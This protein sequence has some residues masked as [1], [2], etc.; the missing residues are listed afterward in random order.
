M[1]PKKIHYCWFGGNDLPELA[2]KCIESWKKYCPDYEIIRWDETNFDIDSNDYVK[3]AYKSKKYAFVTDYVRLYA[4]YT[5][6]GIYMDTDV[7]VLKNLDEFLINKA[8]SGFETPQTI[9]T[10]IMASE[11]K[12][13]IFKELLDYYT[14][15]HFIKEDGNLDKTTN[16][17]IITSIMEEK[18]LKKNNTLQTI[19]DFTLYPKEYFC[20]IDYTTKEKTITENTYTIHWF[21]GSWIS[22]QDK[23]KAKLYK[24]IKEILGKNKAAKISNVIHGRKKN[25]R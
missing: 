19:S 8:F 5:Q 11:C 22:W 20:P 25:E 15:K 23:L 21:A 6:G 17:S 24:S 4:L 3:E 9:P 14:N 12:L 16:V 13:S 1:I 10:G 7:E 2:L 18:G